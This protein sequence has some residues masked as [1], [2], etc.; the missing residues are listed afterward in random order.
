MYE[1]ILAMP[2]CA[3][4]TRRVHSNW[5]SRARHQRKLR[6]SPHSAPAAIIAAKLQ[7]HPFPDTVEVACWA[8]ELNITE[9][10]AFCI[11]GKLLPEAV[12][13]QARFEYSLKSFAM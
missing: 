5:A 6:S 9:A 4:Y 12:K 11:V 2:G 13:A 1:T 8:L 10:E 7:V 3:G